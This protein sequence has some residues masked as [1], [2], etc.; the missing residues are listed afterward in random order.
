M[1]TTVKE[2][3][4]EWLQEAAL[5]QKVLDALTDASL[6]QSVW[7]GGRTLGRIAWHITINIPQFLNR[8]GV[9]IEAVKVAAG[10]PISAKEIAE[11]FRSVS[12]N[13]AVG[14][15]E[16]W[17]DATLTQ[18]Q[19]FFGRE[20]PNAVILSQL[21]RHMIHHR[22]QMTILMRQAGLNVPGVYGPSKEEWNRLSLEPPAI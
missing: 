13:V 20:L 4:E 14:A 10:V 8:F 3:K 22:G 7:S 1:F 5:T 2:F 6:Q 11:T 18:V 17:T 9:V 16:Q 15:Q 21:I 19:D 12:A